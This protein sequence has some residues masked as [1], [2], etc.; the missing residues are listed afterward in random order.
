MPADQSE[1]GFEESTKGKESPAESI[2]KEADAG[3]ADL[4]DKQKANTEYLKS[5]GKSGITNEFGKPIIFDGEPGKPGPLDP[6]APKPEP[7]DP[8]RQKPEDPGFKPEPI[9]PVGQRPEDPGFKPEPFDPGFEPEPFEPRREQP[10]TIPSV[11]QEQPKGTSEDR[12]FEYGKDGGLTGFSE[13]GSHWSKHPDGTYIK[14]ASNPPEKR[15]HVKLDPDGGFEYTNP[16]TG[17]TVSESIHGSK[18]VSKPDGSEIHSDSH[19]RVDV[20]NYPPGANAPMRIMDYDPKTGELGGFHEGQDHWKKTPDGSYV[21][22]GSNPPEKRTD[23][24]IDPSTGAFEYTDPK[25]GDHI[26]QNANGSKTT[27]HSDGTSVETDPHGKVVKT[28]TQTTP[29]LPPVP[30]IAGP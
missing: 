7:F 30:P 17:E 19:G 28:H 16:D 14:D 21:K 2:V 11:P 9:N 24:K 10:E 15:T 29:F 26:N 5:G 6:V 8:V 12:S 13:N 1:K 18:T 25:T 4:V 20:I 22:D 3:K 23:V 27:H